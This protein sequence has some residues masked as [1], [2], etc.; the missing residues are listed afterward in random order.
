MI[1]G[2]Y[3]FFNPHKV[4]A[5]VGLED[6]SP[7]FSFASVLSQTSGLILFVTGFYSF[8]AAF[9]SWD[10]FY[11]YCTIVPKVV[12]G[13]TILLFVGFGLLQPA[14]M[15]LVIFELGIAALT[16]LVIFATEPDYSP[17]I[18][19]FC[20]QITLAQ[21]SHA[22]L[23][24]AFAACMTFIPSVVVPVMLPGVVLNETVLQW[25]RIMGTTE[26]MMTWTYALS[27]FV[28]GMDSFAVL[29][30]LT[31]WG[32]GLFLGHTFVFNFSTKTQFFGVLPDCL[33]ALFTFVA[34]RRQNRSEKAKR[35]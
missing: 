29:S 8:Y 24:G 3:Q 14:F 9:Y 13:L 2:V 4:S 20:N 11:F 31:R 1:W 6:L 27:G 21:V 28:V 15:V 16:A 17:S 7:L 12:N 5:M 35:E 18:S 34:V 26:F 32:C 10:A 23:S 25:A 30:V 19:F 33:L 22:T